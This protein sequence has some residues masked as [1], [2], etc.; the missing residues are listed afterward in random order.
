MDEITIKNGVVYFYKVLSRN[1]DGTYLCQTVLTLKL[2][3][4]KKIIKALDEVEN[5]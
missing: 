4:I 1:A 3:D 2:E 5:G